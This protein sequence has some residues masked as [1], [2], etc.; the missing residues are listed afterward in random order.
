MGRVGQ[1]K[2]QPATNAVPVNY[3]V[4]YSWIILECEVPNIL[5]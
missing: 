1:I 4:I 2:T 5:I 3:H